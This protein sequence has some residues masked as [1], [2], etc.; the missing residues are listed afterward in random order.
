MSAPPTGLNRLTSELRSA[1]AL[2]ST[3]HCWARCTETTCVQKST[4][5]NQQQRKIEDK[6][7]FF[8]DSRTQTLM[9][10]FSA[11]RT[12]WKVSVPINILLQKSRTARRRAVLWRF[13]LRQSS[14]CAPHGQ[15]DHVAWLLALRVTGRT[16]LGQWFAS[17]ANGFTLQ[18]LQ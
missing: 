8:T 9:P 15:S 5:I 7:F 10:G 2:I 6:H 11:I 1:G 16:S 14:R 4:S 18:A 12:H 3:V 17:N 13:A